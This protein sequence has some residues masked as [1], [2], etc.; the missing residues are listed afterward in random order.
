MT[1]LVFGLHA[2]QS[3]LEHAPERVLCAWLDSRR[4]DQKLSRLRAK[5]QALGIA[6]E[7]TERKKLDQLAGSPYHQGVV[8]KVRLPK[9]R[10]ERDLEQALARGDNFF[11][12]LD[13]IQDPHNLGACLRTCD[14]VG[15]KGAIV[16][17]D[18]SCPLTA[19]VCKTA[20]GATETVALYRVTNLARTL[21][22]LKEAGLWIVGA[23]S[24]GEQLAFAADLRGPLALVLGGEGQ[25]MRRLT[26]E[27]CDFL[28][29]LPMRGAVESLNLSVA[30]AVLLYEAL[31]QREYR[32]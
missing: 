6:F 22:D 4:S 23:D 27:L 19:V 26:R 18:H 13:R 25:G 2:A 11:L 20:S 8:L 29:R 10:D 32:I 28:V 14:A 17:K 7:L 3:V 9:A 21:G 30:A 12:V 1:E 31:R 5:L 24:R 16:P 15:V